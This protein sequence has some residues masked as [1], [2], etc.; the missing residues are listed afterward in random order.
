MAFVVR[1]LD[2][3]S[4]LGYNADIAEYNIAHASH[5]AVFTVVARHIGNLANPDGFTLMPPN[6]VTVDR[7][8][9]DVRNKN[10]LNKRF[11]PAVKSDSSVGT[12]YRGGTENNAPKINMRFT[13]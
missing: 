6:T 5:F 7:F 1:T 8:D 11:I 4:L 10:I 2:V 3:D 12:T 13:S 9:R